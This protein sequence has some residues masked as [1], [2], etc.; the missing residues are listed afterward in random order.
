MKN[1]SGRPRKPLPIQKPKQKTHAEKC[2]VKK[3]GRDK[4]P[5]AVSQWAWENNQEFILANPK[6]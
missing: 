3:V 5:E 1:R 6:S 2:K 4:V